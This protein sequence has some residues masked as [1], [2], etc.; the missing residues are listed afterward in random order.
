MCGNT[1]QISDT[2]FVNL[3][4]S[5]LLMVYSSDNAA[6]PGVEPRPLYMQT[7]SPMHG[8]L[9]HRDR[10]HSASSDESSTSL[11]VYYLDGIY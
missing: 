2:C 4:C 11:T 8:V 7:S 3:L 1:V 10:K 6:R 9:S 5:F